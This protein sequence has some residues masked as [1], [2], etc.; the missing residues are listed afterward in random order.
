MLI[1]EKIL[2]INNLRELKDE[3]MKANEKSILKFLECSD[4]SYLIPI[5]QRDY[6]WGIEEAKTLFDDL[7]VIS[8]LERKHFLG[9]I[10]T[11]YN[12]TCNNKEYI[13]IDGQ[14]RI[15]TISLL[16]IAIL[17]Y[18]ESVTRSTDTNEQINIL[19]NTYI[20]NDSKRF[21]ENLKLKLKKNNYEEYR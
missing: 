12:H 8:T 4:T 9:S 17:K 1:E 13:V 11:L 21:E 7:V 14:Q 15:I 18:L 2:L 3:K 10:V 5:Y 20:I 19:K 16:L 6:S